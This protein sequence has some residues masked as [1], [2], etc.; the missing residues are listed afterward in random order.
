MEVGNQLYAPASLPLGN[1]A[2]CAPGPIQ[3]IEKEKNLLPL[4]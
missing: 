1:V 4:S 2:G 3:V